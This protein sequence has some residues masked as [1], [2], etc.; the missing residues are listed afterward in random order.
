LTAIATVNKFLSWYV[1]IA[2]SFNHLS[3][4]AW[5]LQWSK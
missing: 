1:F 2:S 3:K 4:R 5:K